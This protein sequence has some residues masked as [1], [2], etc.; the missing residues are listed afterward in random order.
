MKDLSAI[1]DEELDGL[2]AQHDMAA[3]GYEVVGEVDF[4]PEPAEPP[5]PM[6]R[7]PAPLMRP[8]PSTYTSPTDR[9]REQAQRIN[10]IASGR[11]TSG[12]ITDKSIAVGPHANQIPAIRRVPKGQPAT[13]EAIAQGAKDE[14]AQSKGDYGKFITM[15]LGGA[16]GG[17]A[18]R[19]LSAAPGVSTALSGS[20]GR[21]AS[22]AAGT[23][24]GVVEGG[25]GAAATAA[26][27]GRKPSM[28]EI[29]LGAGI[30]GVLR[31]TEGIG[32]GTLHPKGR[33]GRAV[34]NVQAV[35]GKPGGLNPLG[36][37]ARGGMFDEPAYQDLPHGDVGTQQMANQ[38]SSAIRG[39]LAAREQARGAALG[40]VEDQVSASIGNRPID[41]SGARAAL[42]SLRGQTRGAIGEVRNAAESVIGEAD[43]VLAGP[44][45][46]SL[47]PS[48]VK[49]AQQSGNVNAT[50]FEALRQLQ[51]SLNYMADK[52]AATAPLK[53][54]PAVQA[55]GVVRDVVRK[56][57]KRMGPA[58]DQYGK[59]TQDLTRANDL[60]NSVDDATPGMAAAKE[61]GAARKLSGTGSE[62]KGTLPYEPQLDELAG[63]DPVAAEQI[64]RLRARNA[65][66]GVMRPGF[67]ENAGSVPGW[68]MRLLTR[69]ADAASIRLG[70][71]ASEY[72]GALAPPARLLESGLT[73]DPLFQRYRERREKR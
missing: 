55:A 19:A 62:V 42:G 73:I 22:T 29:L 24:V 67:P 44:G 57:D 39:N 6:D 45:N 13:D 10:D 69:N 61:A 20:S 23:G 4:G 8:D 30:G 63:L 40:A 71:P 28:M 48:L 51:K 26:L 31:G 27:Q 52:G 56:A 15:M 50:D 34:Q 58:L 16:A 72:A 7:R 53:A 25:T 1:S 2:I 32:P 68:L 11:D 70:L 46:A 9:A 38:A 64:R 33:T 18:G 36:R 35:G 66:E 43:E 3:N 54:A 41:T 65:A 49:R 17:L 21:L 14:L 5:R 47:T 60:L 12:L 59:E 37:P